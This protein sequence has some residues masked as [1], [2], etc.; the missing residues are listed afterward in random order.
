MF[1]L[2]QSVE[3][4]LVKIG[5]TQE[6]VSI[7]RISCKNAP[8]RG[9]PQ[10]DGQHRLP[11]AD[12]FHDCKPLGL[13]LLLLQP[14]HHAEGISQVFKQGSCIIVS[15]QCICTAIVPHICKAHPETGTT[16][17]HNLGI[18]VGFA[19]I[20]KSLLQRTGP[21]TIPFLPPGQPPDPL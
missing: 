15:H 20:P 19:H 2:F 16:H 17:T 13:S 8:F 10:V 6:P 18:A 9:N 12:I 11:T 21:G 5:A 1:L 4:L 3:H 14:V 7:F